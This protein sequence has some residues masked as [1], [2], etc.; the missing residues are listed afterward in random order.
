LRLIRNATQ[1]IT[2]HISPYLNGLAAETYQFV[3]YL[4]DEATRYGRAV[5]F[6]ATANR[7]DAVM[8]SPGSFAREAKL[9]TLGG[10]LLHRAFDAGYVAHLRRPVGWTKPDLNRQTDLEIESEEVVLRR[11]NYLQRRKLRK[12]EKNRGFELEK[13]LP[14]AEHW[15]D[16][17][18]TK[19]KELVRLA[20][21]GEA[22]F[23]PTEAI[24]LKIKIHAETLYH[25][26]DALPVAE[27]DQQKVYPSDFRTPVVPLCREEKMYWAG[28]GL[29]DYAETA[30]L[31]FKLG[32]Y[33]RVIRQKAASPARAIA[34][35]AS[36][37]L[38][39]MAAQRQPVLEADRSAL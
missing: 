15:S 10:L 26:I 19:K 7:I 8:V 20:R 6:R 30:T 37:V 9:P 2:V 13:I 1:T 21:A 31:L 5:R 28:L 11:A 29:R 16:L 34:S 27:L 25:L 32:G 38:L 14:W 17:S 3:D 4:N 12:L 22:I 18:A 24:W 23:S 39:L 35:D 36:D 33:Q